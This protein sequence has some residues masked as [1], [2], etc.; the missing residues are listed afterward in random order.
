MINLKLATKGTAVSIGQEI[1]RGGEGVIFAIPD[2]PD[3]VAKLYLKDPEPTKVKKLTTMVATTNPALL[4][5]AAWPIDLLVDSQQKLRGFIMPRIAARRDIHE[6]YSPKSRAATFPETDFRFLVH[7]GMNIARAF[8]V[9]HSQ[10]HVIGDVNHGNLLV[11]PDGTV[12]LIDCDSFQVGQGTNAFS[13]DVGVPL[14]TAPELHGKLLRGLVRTPNHDVFGLAVLLF[15]LFFMG[16]HPFAGRY[17]GHGDMPIE[18]AVAEYRFAYGP[19]RQA[20]Q[21]ERPPGTIPLE[22]MGNTVSDLFVRTFERA[23]S[24]GGRP[25]AEKWLNGLVQ[26]RDA[27]GVCSSAKWHYYPRSLSA[28]PWCTV[29]SQTGV[30]LFGQRV[31]ADRFTGTVDVDSLWRAI[32]SVQGPGQDPA[33]PSERQGPPLVSASSTHKVEKVVRQI[34][35]FAIGFGG[36]VACDALPKNGSG[37]WGIAGLIAAYLIW[38]RD[39]PEERLEAERALI[40]A[41]GE[42]EHALSHW[43]NQATQV[44][45]SA[46]F[47]ELVRIRQQLVDLPRKKQ[48]GITKLEKERHERQLERYLDRFRIDRG[49]IPG[50]GQSRTAMLASYGIETAA[51]IK[52]NAISKIPGFGQKLTGELLSWRKSHEHNFQFNPAEPINQAEIDALDSELVTER[53]ALVNTLR[54]GPDQLRRISDET[55]AARSRLMPMLER[56]WKQ[57]QLTQA[58]LNAL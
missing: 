2:S 51:D 20:N 45:F 27:L 42:W 40:A 32:V 1:G 6:L 55:S 17:L 56:C 25:S 54:Q 11:G 57:V 35:A 19:D 53:T 7:V 48:L 43:K 12:I 22:T 38:P 26:L 9:I 31:T 30:R 52:R 47:E 15:H 14:F 29:E 41:K 5:I 10:G 16:R 49:N 4:K 39:S 28:C 44:A 18:K 34:G 46:K 23:G 24:Y 36:L 33:L 8:A 50:I 58:S 3:R 13:C 21:M 37:F